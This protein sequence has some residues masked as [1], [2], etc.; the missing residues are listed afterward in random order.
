MND[1]IVE[2]AIDQPIIVRQGPVQVR[3]VHDADSI[4]APEPMGVVAAIAI[5]PPPNSRR[6]PRVNMASR[7]NYFPLDR[8]DC[9]NGIKTCSLEKLDVA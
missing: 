7:G 9:L 8:D 5:K 6:V 2:I 4:K 3:T 1:M